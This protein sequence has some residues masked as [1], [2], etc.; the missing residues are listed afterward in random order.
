MAGESVQSVPTVQSTQTLKTKK[1]TYVEGIGG[2]NDGVGAVAGVLIGEELTKGNNHLNVACGAGTAYMT[3]LEVGHTFDIGK[4]M[5][6]DLSL[7]GQTAVAATKDKISMSTTIS[8]QDAQDFSANL[9]AK[10]RKMDFRGGAK[11]QLKFKPSDSFTLKAG[12]E[13]GY[14]SN[15]GFHCNQNTAVESSE[16]YRLEIG[17]E[18]NNTKR[19][20]YITPTIDAKLDVSKN[21][22]FTANADTHQGNIGVRYT[23]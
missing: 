14:K 4:N 5:G 23:F 7:A 13:G 1:E 22:S 19:G 11:V 21:L 20:A 6:L 2:Y 12:I 18:Y 16:G 10:Y 8:T 3:K 9:T 15:E 17:R